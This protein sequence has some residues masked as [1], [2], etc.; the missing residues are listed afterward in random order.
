MDKII[1]SLLLALVS[2]IK[3]AAAVDG[4]NC[5]LETARL[6]VKQANEIIETLNLCQS[7]PTRILNTPDNVD[8]YYYCDSSHF[9]VY[10]L[11][12][13]NANDYYLIEITISIGTGGYQY[14]IA[15]K[16]GTGFKIVNLFKGYLNCILLTERNYFDIQLAALTPDGKVTLIITKGEEKYLF[17]ETKNI[18]GKHINTRNKP[19]ILQKYSEPSYW[20]FL[21]E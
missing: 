4:K 1:F 14:W 2:T 12:N 17:K 3:A 8:C 5:I 15:K 9:N 10:H 19:A 16:E 21:E 20:S 18:E 6:P 7:N 13:K 11:N